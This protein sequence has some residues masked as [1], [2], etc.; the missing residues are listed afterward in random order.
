M[1]VKKQAQLVEFLKCKNILKT[2]VS[3][4]SNTNEKDVEFVKIESVNEDFIDE[5]CE[6]E[7]TLKIEQKVKHP[8]KNPIVA[9]QVPKPP[10]TEAIEMVQSVLDDS[11]EIDDD[12]DM[13]EMKFADYAEEITEHRPHIIL[14]PSYLKK[15][16][17]NKNAQSS[18]NTTQ[19]TNSVIPIIIQESYPFKCLKCEII[20]A[21]QQELD[22][23]MIDHLFEEGPQK[24]EQCSSTFKTATH[25]KRHIKNDHKGQKYICN[26]CGNLYLSQPKLVCHLRTHNLTKKFIC[27]FEDCTKA[28][29]LK[30]NDNK[31]TYNA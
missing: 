16:E 6:V 8:V 24:C 13:P 3:D 18:S 25:Y 9:I 15:L 17:E 19:P 12:F 30:V 23:H 22:H 4:S 31:I 1:L 14:H 2:Q 29:R 28:F 27:T 26:V 20:Y 7:E 21:N 10:K 11:I 5:S